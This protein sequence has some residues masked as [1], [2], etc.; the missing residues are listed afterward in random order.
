MLVVLWMGKSNVLD[1]TV[2]D[3]QCVALASRVAKDLGGI[4]VEFQCLGEL[5]GRVGDESD[6]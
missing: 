1:F 3:N 6:L 5:A 2:L 4:E